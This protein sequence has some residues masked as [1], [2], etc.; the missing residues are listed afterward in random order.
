MNQNFQKLTKKQQERIVDYAEV[1]FTDL[2]AQIELWNKKRNNRHICRGITHGNYDRIHTL[3]TPS[4]LVSKL[5]IEE[6]RKNSKFIFTKDHAYRPQFMMQMFMDNPE[7]FLTDF[8]IFLEYIVLASTTILITPEENNKLKNFTKNKNG[9]IL[10][11]VPTDKIYQEAGIELFETQS[12]RGWYN[13]DLKPA[14]NYLPTPDVYLEYEK[15][16]LVN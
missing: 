11:K 5:A 8:N 1:I 14:D 6:K 15:K 9:K 3:S 4:G 7:V 2:R 10:I 13:R 12:G 16:F